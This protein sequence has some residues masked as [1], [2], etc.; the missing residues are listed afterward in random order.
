M[1]LIDLF[2]FNLLS[3]WCHCLF[4]SICLL[5]ELSHLLWARQADIM[6]VRIC[7]SLDKIG[8]EWQVSGALWWIGVQW[9][10]VKTIPARVTAF[11][12]V[13]D[14]YSIIHVFLPGATRLEHLTQLSQSACCIPLG[15]WLVQRWAV[16]PGRSSHRARGISGLWC[17]FFGHEDKGYSLG[18]SAVILPPLVSQP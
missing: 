17:S 1:W 14:F 13:P 16:V 15:M 2:F 12:K 11:L 3:T 8:S 18:L 6:L 7:L 9:T 4:L 10:A 5:R